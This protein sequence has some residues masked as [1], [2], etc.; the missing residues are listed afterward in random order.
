[1][2]KCPRLSDCRDPGSLAQA[3]R[4]A[5]AAAAAPAQAEWLPRLGPLVEPPTLTETFPA[6]LLETPMY[7]GL[8]Q[9]IADVHRRRDL[10]TATADELQHFVDRYRNWLLETHDESHEETDE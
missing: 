10:D 9:A 8:R 2:T 1:M 7:Q 5:L 6:F 3:E 4:H